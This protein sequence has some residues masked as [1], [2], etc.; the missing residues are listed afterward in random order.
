MSTAD[1]HE[2]EVESRFEATFGVLLVIGLQA[3]LALVSLGAGWTLIGLQWWVWLIPVALEA[4]LLLAL[5]WSLPRHRLEQTGLRRTVALTLVGVITVA[6]AFALVALVASLLSGQEKSGSELLLK[7]AT[8]WG[9]NVITFGLL[10]WEFDRGGPIRRRA[11]NP[12][13]RDFQ[14]PQDEN[15]TL[16]EPDWHPRLADYVYISFTNAVAFSP[17]DVMPLTRRVKM[18]MLAEAATSGVTALLVAA[19]AV[20]IL[21]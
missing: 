5:S 9:T 15:P 19:R 21:R 2:E 1:L 11:P 13:P 18:M 17:T 16:A 12:P 14:F 20:N 7:G 6:D 8:I 3:A 10:F 4:A